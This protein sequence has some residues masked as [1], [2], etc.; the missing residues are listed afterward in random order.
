MANR[1]SKKSK[2]KDKA[3]KDASDR[4]KKKQRRQIEEEVEEDDEEIVLEETE[5][6]PPI[7]P[8]AAAAVAKSTKAKGKPKRSARGKPKKS[9]P[10]MPEVLTKEDKKEIKNAMKTV[11][12]DNYWRKVKFWPRGWELQFI[13]TGKVIRRVK[14]KFPTFKHMDDEQKNQFYVTQ[15]P[16]VASA[17]NDL[18]AYVTARMKDEAHKWWKKH[19]KTLPPVDKIL[20][21]LTRTLDLSN[22]EN[23]EIFCFYWDKFMPRATA[24]TFDWSTDKC[25]YAIMST[26]APKDDPE[27]LY[28]TDSTEA[29]AVLCYEN[30]FKC[31]QAIWAVKTANSDLPVIAGK[32]ASKDGPDHEV[33]ND[34][35]YLYGD[36]YKS[37]WCSSD[38]GSTMHG[39][40]NAKGFKKYD[41]YRDMCVATRAK[42]TTKAYEEAF[43]ATLRQAHGLTQASEAADNAKSKSKL[44]PK[45][46][47][48]AS[49]FEV[50]VDGD[51]S[52][53]SESEEED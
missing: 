35:I 22:K 4:Q 45:G 21:C 41:E 11:L 20:A 23:W 47:D 36:M 7:V 5:I 18:R 44:P 34:K 53:E 17:L 15:I 39:G 12:A 14:G 1:N 50:V 27:D 9:A 31:W 30:H 40:Y 13:Q 16:V 3:P 8:V 43:L 37:K 25:R 51:I 29:F 48:D 49:D 26:A 2:K 10:I 24:N 38:C 33:K 28:I 19:D 46:D 6:D 42:P 32:K 52:A